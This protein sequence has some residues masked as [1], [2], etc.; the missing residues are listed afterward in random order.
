MP[1]EKCFTDSQVILVWIRG[2]DKDWKPLVCNR[3]VEIQINVSPECWRHYGAD[4]TDYAD[5][6]LRILTN[7]TIWEQALV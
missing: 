4:E 1:L 2:T 3:V 7:V 6:A 5:L